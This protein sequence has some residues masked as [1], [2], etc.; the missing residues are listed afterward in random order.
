MPKNKSKRGGTRIRKPGKTYPRGSK[1]GRKS[2]M[3]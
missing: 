3:G 2:P 1:G